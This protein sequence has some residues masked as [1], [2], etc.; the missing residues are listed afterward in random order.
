[1]GI[2][3]GFIISAD[4]YVVTNNHFRGQAPVNAKMLEGMVT[5]R[6]VSAPEELVAAFPEALKPF[7]E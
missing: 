6:K 5:G 3:S 2:G 1:M 7:V 4:G